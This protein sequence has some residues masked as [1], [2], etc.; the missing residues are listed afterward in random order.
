MVF[1]HSV[2]ERS[3][4]DAPRATSS[5]PGWRLAFVARSP[6][7]SAGSRLTEPESNALD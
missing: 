7:S 5:I 4:N 6:E 2:R 1:G 3:H